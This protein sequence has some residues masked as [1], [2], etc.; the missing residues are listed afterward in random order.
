MV[1]LKGLWLSS[2]GGTSDGATVTLQLK[3]SRSADLGSILA[4]LPKVVST[5]QL[6][7]SVV[8]LDSRL[9]PDGLFRMA[10]IKL[11]SIST[12]NNV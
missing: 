5:F 9:G 10:A 7:G 3:S 1:Y 4:I 2:L 11:N 12:H 6:P 8:K